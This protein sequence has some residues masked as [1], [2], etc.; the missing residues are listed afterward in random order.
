MSHDANKLVAVYI[1][2]RDKKSELTKEY[3]EKVAEIEAQMVVIESELL[4]ICKETGQTGGKTDKGTFRKT[5][6]SRYWT[7]NWPKMY[8]FIK[9][10]NAIELLEQ[11]IH[12][13]HMKAF[14]EDNPDKLPEGLNLESKY[15]IVVR[16]AS[17]K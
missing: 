10:H 13:T 1:K 15:S 16:R 3:E 12:Q 6:R 7:T 11:R 9:E 4:E 8:E 14:L 5:V 2:M 17:E